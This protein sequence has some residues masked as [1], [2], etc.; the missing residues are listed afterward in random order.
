MKGG[1]LKGW[2]IAFGVLLT[3]AAALAAQIPVSMIDFAFSPDSVNIGQGDEIV[4]TNNGYYV[5]TSTSGVNGVPDGTWNS[6]DVSP[7]NTYAH[8]FATSGTFR[9]YCMHHYTSGMKG[10]VVVGS[11]G[12]DDSRSHAGSRYGLRAFPNPFRSTS[13]LEFDAAAGTRRVLRVYDVSG[14]MVRS[15]VAARSNARYRASWDGRDDSGRELPAGVY[16]CISGSATT[17]LT[18]LD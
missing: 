18:K 12:I 17:T 11:S 10:V 2:T 1:T 4:W 13:T 5:H 9:Y 3:I 6:G 7:G 14:Q 15:F 8:T 16:H